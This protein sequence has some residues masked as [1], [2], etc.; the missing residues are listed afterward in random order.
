M[1]NVDNCCYAVLKQNQKT[2][3]AAVFF[4]SNKWTNNELFGYVL[5]LHQPKTIESVIFQ[6]KNLMLF[7]KNKKCSQTSFLSLLYTGRMRSTAE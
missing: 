7:L 2:F 5:V 3:G 6:K 4:I 1:E